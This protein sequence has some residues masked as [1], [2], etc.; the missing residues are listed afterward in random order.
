ME[1]AHNFFSKNVDKTCLRVRRV[2][3]SS[4][5]VVI[6]FKLANFFVEKPNLY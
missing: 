2:L 6:F 5:K 3:N 1:N 4:A